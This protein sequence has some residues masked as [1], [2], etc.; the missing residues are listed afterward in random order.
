MSAEDALIVLIGHTLVHLVEGV[1]EQVYED[2]AL[3]LQEPGFSWT[4]FSTILQTT[5]IER[6]GKAL[7]TLAAKKREFPLPAPLVAPPLIVALLAIKTPRRGKGLRT[8]LFR[9]A[10]EL[11][12]V[13]NPAGMVGGY[14][15]KWR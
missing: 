11:F 3:L 5:G 1:G 12:F 9:G 14:L 13:K 7:L 8:M 6:F 15:R 4:R 2:A 10:V